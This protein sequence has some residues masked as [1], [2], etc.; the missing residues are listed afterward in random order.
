MR[1]GSCGMPRATSTWTTSRPAPSP[2]SS[3]SAA[4]G[5]RAPTTRQAP[6]RTFSA[7]RVPAPSRRR[8]CRR[9]TT[10][11]RTW[12]EWSRWVTF[13]ITEPLHSGGGPVEEAVVADDGARGRAVRGQPAVGHEVGDRHVPPQ[14]GDVGDQPPVAPPPHALAA[15]DRRGRLRRLLQQSVERGGELRCPG[16]GGVGRELAD[17]PPAV[18]DRL[19]RRQPAPAA[20]PFVPPITDPG[21]GQPLDE[22]LPGDVG[23]A[24]A[25][26]GPAGRPR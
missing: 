10:A 1:S 24:A 13:S 21:R 25:A 8:S 22:R 16:V 26:P 12:A 2:A 15:H 23:I 18:R 19:A 7:G 5:P 11:T 17:A 9:P 3:P 20:E 14:D 6:P 4:A